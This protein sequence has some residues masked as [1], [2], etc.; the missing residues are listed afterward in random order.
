M[1]ASLPVKFSLIPWLSG[2]PQFSPS[3]ILFAALYSLIN[4]FLDARHYTA[5]GVA[6]TMN[7]ARMAVVLSLLASYIILLQSRIV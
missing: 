1:R 7:R 4:R 6:T 2:Q 5:P 3:Q